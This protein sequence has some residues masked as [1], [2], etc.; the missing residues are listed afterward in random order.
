M[1]LIPVLQSSTCN[2]HKS[3]AEQVADIASYLLPRAQIFCACDYSLVLRWAAQSSCWRK[4]WPRGRSS[5]PRSFVTASW[6]S[7]VRLNASNCKLVWEWNFAGLIRTVCEKCSSM[8]F[9]EKTITWCNFKAVSDKRRY[10]D[11]RHILAELQEWQHAVN[12]RTFFS[13]HKAVN[14]PPKNQGV[15]S[16]CCSGVSACGIHTF[17]YILLEPNSQNALMFPNI[18]T[19]TWHLVPAKY[20]FDECVA[21]GYFASSH[22]LI[23]WLPALVQQNFAEWSN[24]GHH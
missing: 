20:T 15:E 19:Q 23:W 3:I 2:N 22:S 7:Q 14:V 6:S 17:K 16:L 9:L 1:N 12:Y 8:I 24:R 13:Q 21:A 10:H 18:Y 11:H 4:G 5:F